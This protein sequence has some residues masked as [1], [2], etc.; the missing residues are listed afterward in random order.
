[1]SPGVVTYVKTENTAPI[2]KNITFS[3]PTA[4]PKTPP[5]F[6]KISN[7][8]QLRKGGHQ[9]LHLSVVK[10]HLVENV[11]AH[12]AGG[13]DGCVIFVKGKIVRKV[14]EK[15]L[16]KEFFEEINKCIR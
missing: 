9:P 1:M 2:R 8:S 5:Q 11:A 14:A 10:F 12:I 7:P 15:D 16:D 6:A 13:K 4:R 3:L